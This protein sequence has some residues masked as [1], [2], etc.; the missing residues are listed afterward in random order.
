MGGGAWPFL[1]GGVICLV[2]SDNERDSSLLTSRWI[3]KCLVNSDYKD[4]ERSPS[5]SACLAWVSASAAGQRRCGVRLHCRPRSG[6][7]CSLPAV[8]K[9]GTAD[10]IGV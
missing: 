4:R 8:G 7:N 1:V 6:G 3:Y 10:L 5:D 2:N 9:V